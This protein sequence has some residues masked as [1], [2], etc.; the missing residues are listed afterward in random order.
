MKNTADTST[1]DKKEVQAFS[2]IVDAYAFTLPVLKPRERTREEL[3][4]HWTRRPTLAELIRATLTRLNWSQNKLAGYMGVYP[5]Q[6][7]QWIN[8]VVLGMS[9]VR[10]A[11][12]RDLTRRHSDLDNMYSLIEWPADQRKRQR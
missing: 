12:L 3:S 4:W 11:L 6:I 10:R 9:P 5:T 2:G 7:S 1:R 8:G